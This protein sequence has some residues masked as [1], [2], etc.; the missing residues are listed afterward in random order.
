MAHHVEVKMRVNIPAM[1][2]WEVLGDFSSIE[3]FSTA[4]EKSPILDGISSGLGTKRKC[5]FYD[6]SSVIEEIIDYQEGTDM[7]EEYQD[8]NDCPQQP[9]AAL[10][11]QGSK[12]KTPR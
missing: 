1:K 11:D 10:R 8:S 9:L 3:R 5:D 12:K 6:G 4:V 2:V 7:L